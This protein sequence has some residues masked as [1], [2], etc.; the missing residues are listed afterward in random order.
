MSPAFTVILPIFVTLV[1]ALWTCLIAKGCEVARAWGPF[2]LSAATSL[3][4]T[5]TVW[6][7]WGLTR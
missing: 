7:V 1:C 6:L 2:Y 5:F 4:A 3:V